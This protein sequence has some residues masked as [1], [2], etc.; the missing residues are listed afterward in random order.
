MTRASSV[1]A[2]I[3]VVAVFGFLIGGMGYGM[4]LTFQYTEVDEGDV[5]AKRVEG[6][7]F[8]SSVTYV[9]EI[10]N[11]TEY[12]VNSVGYNQVSVGDHIKVYCNAIYSATY[13][14]V[15]IP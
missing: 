3:V 15:V 8:A 6:G 5:T 9:I 2:G 14:V 7:S 12:K 10:N 11:N 13:K 4:F 1:L